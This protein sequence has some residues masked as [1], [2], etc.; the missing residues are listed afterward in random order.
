MEKTEK[1]FSQYLERLLDRIEDPSDPRMKGYEELDRIYQEEKVGLIRKLIRKRIVQDMK[2]GDPSLARLGELCPLAP[3]DGAGT[4]YL[5]TISFKD[6]VKDYSFIKTL[7]FPFKYIERFCYSLEQRGTEKD[8][9]YGF[10]I[11]ILIRCNVKVKKSK[12]I[13][14]FYRKFKSYCSGQNYVDCRPTKNYD[15]SLRYLRGEKKDPSKAKMIQNDRNYRSQNNLEDVY[16]SY[17][18]DE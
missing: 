14:D 15:Q 7:K 3:K 10:H 4:D 5:I 2:N 1:Y 18:L 13:S 9:Y 11:H 8:V 16:Y 6:D 17:K 12:L